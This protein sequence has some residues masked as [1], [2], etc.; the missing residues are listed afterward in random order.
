MKRKKISFSNFG[1]ICE[2]KRCKSLSLMDTTFLT[3]EDNLIFQ[4]LN[5][6]VLL[7]NNPENV[8]VSLES[9]KPGVP[10]ELLLNLDTD[11]AYL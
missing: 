1:M 6:N 11:L 8:S 2:E 9:E 10:V 7:A 3:V 5:D 4:I